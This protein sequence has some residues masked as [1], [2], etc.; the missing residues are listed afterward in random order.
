MNSKHFIDQVIP[1]ALGY[2][3][4]FKI[5]TSEGGGGE[6][7]RKRERKKVSDLLE[8]LVAV[9]CLSW[10]LGTKFTWSSGRAASTVNQ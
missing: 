1:L 6:G 2:C 3:L 4:L 7:E 10:G 9:S 8:F 5:F